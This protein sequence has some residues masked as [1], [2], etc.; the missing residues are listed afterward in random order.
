MKRKMNEV[1]AARDEVR[2]QAVGS[3]DR[4]VK[5]RTYNFSAG[6]RNRIIGWR[7]S[8]KNYPLR[9]IIEG[10]LDEMLNA[11]QTADHADRMANA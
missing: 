6:S 8:S 4:S 9:K 3:G 7:G 1:N 5:I 10:E 11:L 2:R